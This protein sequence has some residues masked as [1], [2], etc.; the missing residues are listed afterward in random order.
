M[1]W[2]E[3][4]LVVL[5]LFTGIV[6]LLDKLLLAKRRAANAGLL[7]AK[8]PLVIDYSKA[9]F[10]VLAVV[11]CLQLRGRTVP[12]PLQFDDADA[13]DRRLH[14]RQQVRLRPAVADQQREVHRDRRT[15]ARRRG[16]VPSA[17]APRPG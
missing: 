5:T 13:A 6:W 7:E 16:G 8:E 12:H 9:F 4:A 17:P 10:P 15:R 3:I 14:P 1:R 11:L 2:F